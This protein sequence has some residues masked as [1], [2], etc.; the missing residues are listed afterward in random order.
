MLH[1]AR[2]RPLPDY[3]KPKLQ[4]LRKRQPVTLCIAAPC[5]IRDD[6]GKAQSRI[7]FGW[8]TREQN[9][10][11][12]ADVAFKQGR[13]SASLIALMSGDGSAPEDFLSTCKSCL[14][15]NI[16]FS[17]AFDE[18]NAA[19]GIHKKKLCERLAQ[20][21]FGMDYERV[22][23]KGQEEIPPDIRERFFYDLEKLD[24][25]FEVILLGFTPKGAAMVFVVDGYEVRDCS[26]TFGTAGSGAVI[27]ETV[28]YQRKQ[29]FG[30][31]QHFTA[32]NLYE[33]FKLASGRAPGVGEFSL[34]VGSPADETEDWMK[35]QFVNGEGKKLLER[36]FQKHGPR[37][38]KSPPILAEKHFL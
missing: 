19:V 4:R 1:N 36:A 26:Q 22:L 25:G 11:T 9:Q 21:R 12:G 28:L 13:A 17:T 27:A 38:L 8:D 18:I 16:T 14:S 24:P 33:A 7:V 23:T 10:F 3:L 6:T 29:H 2:H 15:D 30:M 31:H 35:Q 32:Y 20:Q 34:S 5:F 37:I